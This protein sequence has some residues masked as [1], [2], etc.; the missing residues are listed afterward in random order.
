MVSYPN[1]SNEFISDPNYKEYNSDPKSDGDFYIC[2]NCG[3][4]FPRV[5]TYEELMEEHIK[6]FGSVVD[7][8]VCVC[9]PCYEKLLKY[10]RKNGL[11]GES[12]A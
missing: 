5:C 3:G 10:C 12:N 2:A 8:P 7:D 11:I 6:N 4:K 1:Q 9:T